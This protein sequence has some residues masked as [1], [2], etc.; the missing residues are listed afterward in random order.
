MAYDMQYRLRSCDFD[1]NGHIKPASVLDIF[2]DVAGWD[3]QELGWGSK[4]LLKNKGLLWVVV[5]TK[6]EVLAPVLEHSLVK[7][8]TWTNTPS[9]FGFRREY[10]LENTDGA[11]LIKS[12]SEWI[13]TDI[14]TRSFVSVADVWP[15]GGDKIKKVN[16]EGRIKKLR[17]FEV[18]PE[19]EL[20]AKAESIA[21]PGTKL[22]TDAESSTQAKA[23]PKTSSK[24]YPVL[25]ANS[26]LDCNGHVNNTYYASW[27]MDAI[28]LPEN[29]TIKTLQIDYRK[30]VTLGQ[31]I[32]IY[33]KRT[34]NKIQ[35]KGMNEEGVRCFSAELE[36]A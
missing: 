23:S 11:A 29:E 32:D 25:A 21:A 34:G 9:R 5:R 1:A 13:M 19:A 36:L 4:D 12:S 22:D 14:K 28:D 24:P 7:A 17:D 2:Q 15:E 16:F 8:K 30:E 20:D 27:V 35:A 33:S 10:L 6:Y 3:V 18:E 26:M 31:K